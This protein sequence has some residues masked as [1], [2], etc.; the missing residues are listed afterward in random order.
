MTEINGKIKKIFYRGRSGFAIGL[1]S[2]DDGNTITVK[3]VLPGIREG[4]K[5]K[6]S[7][8]FVVD[9]KYGKQFNVR[10]MLF[11][12]EEIDEEGLYRMIFVLL[13]EAAKNGN[14]VFFM[15]MY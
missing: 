3:G 8:D 13:T 4:I 6:L 2:V 5:C 7:G 11:D 15:R 10:H 1:F 14:T 9:E 12:Q